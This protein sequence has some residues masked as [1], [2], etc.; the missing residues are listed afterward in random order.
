M[1]GIFFFELGHETVPFR[2]VAPRPAR[3]DRFCLRI[4]L[5]VP[6]PFTLGDGVMVRSVALDGRQGYCAETGVPRGFSAGV[7]KYLF[8]GKYE[9]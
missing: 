4:S 9:Y 5:P 6:V 7:G 3:T 2:R 1:D 8:P